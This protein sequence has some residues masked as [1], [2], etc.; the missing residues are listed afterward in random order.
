MTTTDPEQILSRLPRDEFFDRETESAALHSFAVSRRG[1]IALVLGVPRV[2]KTELLRKTFDRLF[3]EGGDVAPFYYALKPY[4]VEAEKF[5]RDYLSQFLAQ[6][7]AFRRSDARLLATVDEPLAV[8]SR[9]ALPEDYLWLRAVVDCFARASESGDAAM[10]ARIALS[11]PQTAAARTGLA[12]F[13]M[14]DNFH[15]LAGPNREP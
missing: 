14:I 5:A 1:A 2:G 9:A 6:L 11:A 7:I 10:M 4:A 3:S 12:P 13:V 15:L 8:L